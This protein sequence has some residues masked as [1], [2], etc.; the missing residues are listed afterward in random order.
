MLNFSIYTQEKWHYWYFDTTLKKYFYG[1]G[2][3]VSQ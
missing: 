3:Q 1:M 2:M